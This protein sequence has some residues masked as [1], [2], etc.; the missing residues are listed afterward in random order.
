MEL[1]KVVSVGSRAEAL[2]SGGARARPTEKSAAELCFAFC[3]WRCAR[4]EKPPRPREPRLC[5]ALCSAREAAKAPRAAFCVWRGARPEKPP[6]PES[7]HWLQGVGRGG[8]GASHR[9]GW[10]G[11][12]PLGSPGYL[13]PRL[14]Q[15]VCLRK[16]HRRAH[17]HTHRRTG[18]NIHAHTHTR[19]L[20]GTPQQQDTKTAAN[21]SSI[22]TLT[23]GYGLYTRCFNRS[24][25]LQRLSHHLPGFPLAIR[26]SPTCLWQCFVGSNAPVRSEL[27]LQ[28][29]SSTC[30]ESAFTLPPYGRP[31]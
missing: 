26:A 7:R 6:R 17:L 20:E 9:K 30:A 5:L 13:G 28:M 15:A 22:C 21:T 14:F 31:L 18:A 4:P 16:K 8:G 1:L 2:G 11:W 29:S 24:E 19:A 25:G 12:V 3:V 27:I 10:A 23:A